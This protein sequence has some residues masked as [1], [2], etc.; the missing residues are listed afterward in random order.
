MNIEVI[1]VRK[2][3]KDEVLNKGVY[4]DTYLKSVSKNR[5]VVK[6]QPL[7]KGQPYEEPKSFLEKGAGFT[8]SEVKQLIDEYNARVQVKEKGKDFDSDKI[9]PGKRRLVL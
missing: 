7:P 3:T 4:N 6:L 1:G 2:T 8:K 9:R 5:V